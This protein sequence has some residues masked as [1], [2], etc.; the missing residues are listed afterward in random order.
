MGGLVGRLVGQA[1]MAS[2]VGLDSLT[3]AS[4]QVSAAAATPGEA[5]TQARAVAEGLREIAE[6]GGG[7]ADVARASAEALE[8]VAAVDPAAADAMAQG[9]AHALAHTAE[10][11]AHWRGELE[12]ASPW[13]DETTKAVASARQQWD[14]FAASLTTTLDAAAKAGEGEYAQAAV[15]GLL[16]DLAALDRS[17]AGASEVQVKAASLRAEFDR[18]AGIV[19]GFGLDA[20]TTV[21]GLTKSLD[22]L[23]RQVQNDLLG[24]ID[25]LTSGIG[26]S[27]RD[28]TTSY[29]ETVADLQALSTTGAVEAGAAGRVMLL[30]AAKTLGLE[31]SGLAQLSAEQLARVVAGLDP[32]PPALDEAAQKVVAL[33]TSAADLASVLEAAGVEAGVAAGAWSRLSKA[34]ADAAIKSTANRLAGK[35]YLTTLEETAAEAE[36]SWWELALAG[37]DWAQAATNAAGLVAESVADLSADELRA[38]RREYEAAGTGAAHYRTVMAG[39]TKALGTATEA[40]A[41][42]AANL[43]K[44]LADQLA[45]A[46]AGDTVEDQLALLEREWAEKRQAYLEQG[47]DM[48]LV[49]ELQGLAINKIIKEFAEKAVETEKE[50]QQD[51]LAA[52]KDSYDKAKT[53][54]DYGTSTGQTLRAYVDSLRSS[55]TSV[56]P[57]EAYRAAQETFAG[58]LGVVA[59]SKNETLVKQALERLP[60][61]A[62]AFLA[63][64]REA[65]GGSAVHAADR[66]WVE[67]SLGAIAEILGVSAYDPDAEQT[68]ILTAL[69]DHAASIALQ[70]TAAANLLGDLTRGWRTLDPAGWRAE[71]AT[72]GAVSEAVA[73]QTW[74]AVDRNRDAVL[75]AGEV[76][77]AYA[78]Q[79]L[80]R[81]DALAGGLGALLSQGVGDGVRLDTLR[82]AVLERGVASESAIVRLHQAVDADGNGMLSALEIT[83]ALA[84]QSLTTD[85]VV[86]NTLAALD[87]RAAAMAAKLAAW[88]TDS[89]GGLGLKEFTALAAQYGAS[90]DEAKRIFTS[91][92]GTNKGILSVAQLT[93]D[94][95]WATALH[96][97]DL[98]PLAK[99]DAL[100]SS[101]LSLFGGGGSSNYL[102]QLVAAQA[103][104]NGLLA[105]IAAAEAAGTAPGP[106]AGGTVAVP[107]ALA[108]ADV[109]QL[110][111]QYLA[112]NPDVASA[113]AR[114][115]KELASSWWGALGDA[116]AYT[117]DSAGGGVLSVTY[118]P[119]TGMSVPTSPID[120]GSATLPSDATSLALAHYWRY[121]AAEGRTLFEG[122]GRTDLKTLHGWAQAYA[123]RNTDVYEAWKDDPGQL[124]E[125]T[126]KKENGITNI[127]H[128]IDLNFDDFMLTHWLTYGQKEGRSFADG[129]KTPGPGKVQG[130]GG[131]RDDLAYIFASPG[132]YVSTAA[133]TAQHE[134][135][136]ASVNAGR[137]QY[138]DVLPALVAPVV[139]PTLLPSTSG[140]IDMSPLLDRLDALVG[141][142]R[143]VLALVREAD[144]RGE[145]RGARVERLLSHLAEAEADAATYLRWLGSA[146]TRAGRV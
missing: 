37:G 74:A 100:Y 114:N 139:V 78:L 38:L 96:T 43:N 18:L 2:G 142:G 99:D 27:L 83:N 133:A 124:S 30:G 132:E 145:A 14:E 101:M 56:S 65:T 47:A 15:R 107:R 129:G 108:T 73:A 106:G 79:S 126:V 62:D 42:E 103:T 95:T 55:T 81:S 26:S 109:A 104:A 102:S 34:T 21:V 121:G 45:E 144:T 23:S 5:G 46:K 111:A 11:V 113:T 77:A 3:G 58:A 40:A 135:L 32:L 61:L 68:A 72:H 128:G 134:G 13:G 75:D 76:Q 110:A 54:A 10:R 143:E 127:M 130:P 1:A 52:L 117:N 35:A 85:G 53:L 92:D 94:G 105:Q 141:Q 36:A 60:T 146:L 64:S 31:L 51:R 44:D 118:D 39:L 82:G 4:T 140:S 66:A 6:R 136:L 9:V 50:A 25:S 131:P 22:G 88:D 120:W 112:A 70:T 63:A 122:E 12:A 138:L 91:L 49:F 24:Q 115:P 29:R 89:D 116:R 86:A 71:L 16:T 28:L 69:R 137:V 97:G 84:W 41:K 17:A 119:Q 8:Q 123:E 90:A 87:G 80:L 19:V 48:A 67:A 59:T 33:R 57:R 93:A 7:A 125:I 98:G 20:Q